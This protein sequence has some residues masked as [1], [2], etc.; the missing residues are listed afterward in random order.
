MTLIIPLLQG[1]LDKNYSGSQ[2]VITMALVVF[3]L[4]LLILFFSFYQRLSRLE[5]WR[6]QKTSEDEARNKEWTG[7]YHELDKVVNLTN[8][9][10]RNIKDFLDDVKKRYQERRL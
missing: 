5:D 3:V 2:L 9:G 6:E 7:K 10:V 4:L 8:E 1:I